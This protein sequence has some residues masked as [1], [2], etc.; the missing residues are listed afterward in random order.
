MIA[1]VVVV[2]GLVYIIGVG[3][4]SVIPQVFWP[5]AADTDPAISCAEGLRGL[6]GE[7]LARAGDHVREGGAEQPRS[8]RPFLNDWDLRHRGLERRCQGAGHD[9]WVRLG[10]MRGRLQATLERFD[11]E[12]GALARQLESTLARL[13]R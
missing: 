13:E 11:G 6:R 2:A 9:A 8:L 10:Q 4:I 7:L 3:F 12:E 1:T 5:E